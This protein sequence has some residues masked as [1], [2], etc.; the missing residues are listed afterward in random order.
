[1]RDP[2]RG[3]HILTFSMS[4]SYSLDFMMQDDFKFIFTNKARAPEATEYLGIWD[5]K[6]VSDSAHSPTIFRFKYLLDKGNLNI[7]YILGGILPLG[8]TKVRFTEELM[9]SFDFTGQAIRNELRLVRKDLML[10]KLCN[11]DNSIFKLLDRS[12]GFMMDDNEKTCLPYTLLR[13]A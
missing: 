5:V 11:K 7:K 6:L 1:I 10:G 8:T 2:P 3:E 4:R 9:R 12:S 13:I